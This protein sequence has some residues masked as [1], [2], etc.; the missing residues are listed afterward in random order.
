MEDSDTNAW[1][2][3]VG[4]QNEF[5]SQ[6]LYIEYKTN[7]VFKFSPRFKQKQPTWFKMNQENEDR[8]FLDSYLSCGMGVILSSASSCL[9]LI[10]APAICSAPRRLTSS[11]LCIYWLTH[12]LLTNTYTPLQVTHLPHPHR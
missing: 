4:E 3:R 9:P 2:L 7:V 8:T 5:C 1:T 10:Y 6:K 12:N 11:D